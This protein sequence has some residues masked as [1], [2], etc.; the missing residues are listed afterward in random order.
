LFIIVAESTEIL[1]PITQFGCAQAW[2]GVTDAS[3]A[4]SRVR[5]G[6]PDAVRTMW[7][8]AASQSAGFVGR[9]WKIA[10]CSLS[11]GI[12]VAPPCLTASTN[13]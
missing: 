11:I 12:S 13:S 3:V 6:P 5:N 9:H 8:T 1:R 7:S 10:E 2:S 4:G